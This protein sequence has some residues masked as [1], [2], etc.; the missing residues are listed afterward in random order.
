[1]PSLKQI[2]HH[3]QFQEDARAHKNEVQKYVTR[4]KTNKW[5][6]QIEKISKYMSE[7]I[8][9][10][11]SST[12]EILPTVDLDLVRFRRVSW[13]LFFDVL[14]EE[15]GDQFVKHIR[16]AG[17]EVGCSFGHDLMKTLKD[18]FP[19]EPPKKYER[20]LQIWAE[21]DFSAGWGE[22]GID[23]FNEEE[24]VF[25]IDIQKSFTTRG[26]EEE[27][28]RHCAFIEGYLEGVLNQV[29]LEWIQ[30]CREEYYA[31]P[32]RLTCRSVKESFQDSARSKCVFRVDLDEE[33]LL[34]SRRIL[35]AALQKYDEND[36]PGSAIK[37]RIA[38]EYPLKEN[39]GLDPEDEKIYASFNAMCRAYKEEGVTLP[40]F[41]KAKDTYF[42]LSPSAA[43]GTRPQKLTQEEA[44]KAL[45]VA[46]RWILGL[47]QISLSAD[48]QKLIREVI[49]TR[50]TEEEKP[51]VRLEAKRD[52]VIEQSTIVGRD[53]TIKKEE[54]ED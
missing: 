32:R 14:E 27:P 42:K 9:E 50:R 7:K 12:P 3:D 36:F 25:N 18:E 33:R 5:K 37:A 43:H 6:E 39:V 34:K 49:K 28:H 35:V 48:K 38:L 22:I 15:L 23:G 19:H 52:I 1:M 45:C 46:R 26:Y 16:N 13:Q 53:Q 30:W 21:F 40:L 51:S 31:P 29:F 44:Y 17:E 54:T 4:I 47:E 8:E 10:V 41:K 2:R 11:L 20:V 24:N